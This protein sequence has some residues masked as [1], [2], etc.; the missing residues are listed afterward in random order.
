MLGL[1]LLWKQMDC[2][3]SLF[4]INGVMETGII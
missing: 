1:S 2:K 4:R 3:W